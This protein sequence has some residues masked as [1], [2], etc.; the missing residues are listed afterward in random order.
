ME[1]QDLLPY[2]VVTLDTTHW[3]MSAL[4]AAAF[5]KAVVFVRRKKKGSVVKWIK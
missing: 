3:L 5:L 2:R 1:R 4:N